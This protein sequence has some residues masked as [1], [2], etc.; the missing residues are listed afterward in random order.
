EEINS[1]DFKRNVTTI[2]KELSKMERTAL[3]DDFLFGASPVIYRDQHRMRALEQQKEM[4]Q[5]V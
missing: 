2:A 1:P 4:E 3:E 5:E